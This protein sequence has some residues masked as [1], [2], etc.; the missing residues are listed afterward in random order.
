MLKQ[1]L[2]NDGVIAHPTDTV[3]GLSGSYLSTK[4]YNKIFTIKKRPMDKPLAVLIN[5]CNM[6]SLFSD[7]TTEELSPIIPFLKRGMTILLKRKKTLPKHLLQQ[8]EMIGLRIPNHK[9]TLA[10]IEECGPLICTSAN[11]S[12]KAPITTKEEAEKYFGDDALF[13]E[14]EAGQE[15]IASTILSFIDGNYQLLR[16]GHISIEEIET[17][18]P[19]CS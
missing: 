16:E 2:K 11:I 6:I 3:C 5:D 13:V 9:E 10:I 17:K 7:I 14:G 1:Y 4:A 15:N 18:V 12:G 19:L 8:S